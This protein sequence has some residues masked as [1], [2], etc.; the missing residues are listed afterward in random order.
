MT[1]LLI[2]GITVVYAVIGTAVSGFTAPYVATIAKKSGFFSEGD[3]TLLGVFW[4]IFI[5][6]R[7]IIK[8]TYRL[9]RKGTMG[10]HNV[11]WRHSF[12]A[13]RKFLERKRLPNAKV[14]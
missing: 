8:P 14:E 2:L 7:M 5:G 6:F 4:P 3:H 9:I 12:E 11:I 1:F 13:G 10:C